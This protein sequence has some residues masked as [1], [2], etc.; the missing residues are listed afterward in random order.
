MSVKHSYE[1]SIKALEASVEQL[2]GGELSL[3][4][5]LQVFKDAVRHIGSCRKAL[6]Q[7]EL[8][9]ARLQKLEDGNFSREPFD[10]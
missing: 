10:E 7:T 9:V 4:D 5:S 3:E 6:Q 1:E 8:E 2:E